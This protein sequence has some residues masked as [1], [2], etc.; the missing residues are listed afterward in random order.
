MVTTEELLK[1][2][3]KLTDLGLAGSVSQ[4]DFKQL[5]LYGVG[6][7]I[8]SF[9]TYLLRE[10]YVQ[11]V[12]WALYTTEYA[13]S[14]ARLFKGK[15]VLEVCAGNGILKKMMTARGVTWQSVDTHLSDIAIRN[16]VTKEDAIVAAKVYAY[17]VLFASWI[18][19]SSMLDIQLA[20]ISG[21]KKKPFVLVGESSGCTG[22]YEF[23]ETSRKM[24]PPKELDPK[25][26]DV[27]R[28]P[29]TR[30]YTTIVGHHALDLL[31]DP[32]A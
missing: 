32:I 17:D 27:T 15:I 19:Y 6:P 9:D 24:T 21:L 23:W 22:S 25:F 2:Q 26:Q 28:W 3:T 10:H 31:P 11:H 1:A 14:L 29:N 4:A 16:G 7:F 13:D 5:A 20:A 12:S 8:G 30:D 18:P